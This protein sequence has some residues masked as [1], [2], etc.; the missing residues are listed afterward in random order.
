MSL[1]EIVDG[2]NES[3]VWKAL[4]KLE[5]MLTL[6]TEQ[7]EVLFDRLAP[8]LRRPATEDINPPDKET[9][10]RSEHCVIVARLDAF[11]EV[12]GRVC[13]EL[14]DVRQKLEI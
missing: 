8:L 9:T 5:K 4:D 2:S 3:P 13:A 1:Q 7:K 6:L 12:I 10:S 11:S 14:N